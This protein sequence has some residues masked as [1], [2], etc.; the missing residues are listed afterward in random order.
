MQELASLSLAGIECLHSPAAPRQGTVF[1][2][3]LQK[4][5]C[6]ILEAMSAEAGSVRFK[7]L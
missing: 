6:L 2:K 3:F 1:R 5:V 7:T 4:A